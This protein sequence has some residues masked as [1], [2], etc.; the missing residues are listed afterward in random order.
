[1]QYFSGGDGKVH[2]QAARQIIARHAPDAVR[3]E[4]P[5]H[6]DVPPF[7]CAVLADAWPG[8]VSAG[9]RFEY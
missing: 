7:P 6:E 1:V 5:G 4:E 2:G 9:Q 3:S 8:C